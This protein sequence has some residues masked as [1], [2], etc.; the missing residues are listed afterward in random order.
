MSGLRES[1]LLPFLVI[2][3]FASLA[4]SADSESLLHQFHG[5]KEGDSPSSSLIMDAAGNLFGTT[6]G[7]GNYA[8]S[9]VL[10]C[11]TV[12]KLSPIV[13]GGWRL[14]GIHEFTGGRDGGKS[15]APLLMDKMGNLYGTTAAGGNYG[16]GTAFMLSPMP[17]GSWKLSGLHG[18]G[19]GLD[20]AQPAT[21]LT[22]DTTGNLYGTTVTGGRY[23][24]GTVFRLSPNSNGGWTETVIHSFHS[25]DGVFPF[26]SVIFDG[27]GNLYGTTDAGGAY[28]FGNVFEL[29]P[30]ANGGW[31]VSTLYSFT[32][33]NDGRAPEGAIVFGQDGNLYGTTYFGGNGTGCVLN[34]GVVYKLTHNADGTWSESV[35]YNFVGG[36]DGATPSA[37]LT[38]DSVGNLLGTTFYGGD[39]PDCYHNGGGGNGCGTVFELSPAGSLD[40]L[41]Q[42]HS[43]AVSLRGVCTVSAPIMRCLRAVKAQVATL[44]R[45]RT[46]VV[47]G[48]FDACDWSH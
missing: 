17:N 40:Y 31:V 48:R 9:C 32:G 2:L 46:F 27:E 20:G 18:F 42:S 3:A 7:G 21:G 25:V 38:F 15:G 8:S 36:T 29:S 16:L 24:Y 22:F 23:G 28:G 5:L 19:G 30:N 34:C 37:G 14:T 45:R 12:F 26:A 43:G 6:S 41:E 35:I 11:G 4:W 33:G 10:G 1:S 13:G 47:R 39:Q 44:L